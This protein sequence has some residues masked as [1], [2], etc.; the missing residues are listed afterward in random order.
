MVYLTGGGHVTNADLI[1]PQAGLATLICNDMERDEAAKT[2]LKIGTLSEFPLKQLLDQSG[3]NTTLA[4]ALRYKQI[5]THLNL[6]KGRV[7][8]FGQIEI[9]PQYAVLETT[10]GINARPRFRR[11]L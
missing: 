8:L 3:G 5:L 1:L 4:I 2:G 6:L 7:A 11:I 9:G 10:R